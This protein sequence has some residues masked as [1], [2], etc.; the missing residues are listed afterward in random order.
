LSFRFRPKIFLTPPGKGLAALRLALRRLLAASG[1]PVGRG[2]IDVKHRAASGSVG[3]TDAAVH[4]G[5]QVARDAEAEAAA[6]APAEPSAWVKASN[7]SVGAMPYISCR[8]RW[9]VITVSTASGPPCDIFSSAAK[10]SAIF[11]SS[12]EANRARTRATCSVKS[13]AVIMGQAFS[14]VAQE[15]VIRLR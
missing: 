9:A 12:L 11:A 1:G 6:A 2:Q 4:M 10:L 8:W 5:H 15:P 13:S 14:L 3:K 7:P